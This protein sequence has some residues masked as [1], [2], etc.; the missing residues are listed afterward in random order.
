MVIIGLGGSTCSGKEMLAS[1]LHEHFKYRVVRL[2]DED[3]E[4]VL[5][6]VILGWHL[7]TVVYPIRSKK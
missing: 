3:S 4:K 6:D 2:E 7:P 5:N 1:I